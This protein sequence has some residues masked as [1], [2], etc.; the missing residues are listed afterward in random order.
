[1]G[2]QAGRA[3][4]RILYESHGEVINTAVYR[5]MSHAK[6]AEAGVSWTIEKPTH[7]SG[8]KGSTAVI[9]IHS[10]PGL[11]VGNKRAEGFFELFAL[12]DHVEHAMLQQKFGSLKLIRQLLFNGLLDHAGAGKPD[13]RFRFGQNHIA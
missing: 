9:D 1:M 8:M 4:A 12:H 3:L 11:K 2:N 6:T 7:V 13:Q 5:D 10:E